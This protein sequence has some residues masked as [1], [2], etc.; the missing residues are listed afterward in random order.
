MKKLVWL[1][2]L[3]LAVSIVFPNGLPI[4]SFVKPAPEVVEPAGPTDAAI[5]K[6]LTGVTPEDRARIVGVYTGLLNVLGRDKTAEL[7]NTTDKWEIVQQ[8]TLSVAIDKPGKYAGLDVAIEAVF[9]KTVGTDD[10]LPV[11]PDTV[12]K[13]KDACSIVLNSA[14]VAK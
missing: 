5:V 9:L 2:G 13:L 12:K 1:A 7:M 10:V 3:L 11:T 14:T 8:N 4:K 6:A